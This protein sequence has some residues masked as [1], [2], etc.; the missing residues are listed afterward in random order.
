MSVVVFVFIGVVT[1]A[2]LALGL[3]FGFG[4]TPSRR[5]RREAAAKGPPAVAAL[6]A[7]QTGWIGGRSGRGSSQA[8]GGAAPFGGPT[9]SSATIAD[10][11]IVGPGSSGSTMVHLRLTMAGAGPPAGPTDVDVEVP[12]AQLA[13]LYRGATVPV[14]VDRANTTHVEIDWARI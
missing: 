13:H 10:V 9:A 8:V 11:A 4:W 5:E 2:S 1:A 6:W 3:W 7:E 12:A 14:L